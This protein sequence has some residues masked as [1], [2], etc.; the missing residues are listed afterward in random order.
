MGLGARSGR[1]DYITT[2]TGLLGL[3][4]EGSDLRVVDFVLSCRVMGRNVEKTMITWAVSRARSLDLSRVCA[5]YIPTTKN[6]PCLQFLGRSGLETNPG[7]SSF[8]WESA[9]DYPA[10][11]GVVLRGAEEPRPTPA[12]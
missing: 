11:D 6:Q 9:A 4:A 12:S 10:P 1:A 5:T 3:T 2:K 7:D 8:W